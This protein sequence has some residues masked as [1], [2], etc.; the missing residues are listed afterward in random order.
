VRG[1]A[2]RA[3]TGR[4]GQQTA[5]RGLGDDTATRGLGDDTATRGE[6]GRDENTATHSPGRASLA[7]IAVILAAGGAITAA[8]AQPSPTPLSPAP[9]PSSPAAPSPGS[10]TRPAPDAS[11]PTPKFDH[12]AHRARKVAIDAC[13]SCHGADP[14]GALLAPGRSGH[15]PCLAAGCHVDQFLASGE[16][17]RKA[18]PARHAAAAAFCRG[19]HAT[20]AGEAPR[21]FEKARAD[22]VYRGET[23]PEHHIEMDHLAHVRLSAC[24]DC[25]AVDPTS[26]QLVADRPAHAECAACH[27]Q[28][29]PPMSQCGSCHRSPGPAAYFG[30]ARR[31]S[32]V[33]SCAPGTRPEPGTNPCFLHERREHR[34]AGGA[35]LQCSTCH[36][37]IAD[38]GRW[39]R[40]K[41]RTLRDLAAAPVIHNQR[42]QAHKSC[43][44]SGCHRRDVDD[45]RGTARC[46][47]CHSKRVTESIFD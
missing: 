20:A 18:D 47:L 28:S 46:S 9:A 13:A 32:D 16:A 41:Y 39:G 4:P 15:Q 25:H 6:R 34:F 42:D 1:A 38:P 33:R 23:A 43:G 12:A 19:C 21:R 7:M 3:A 27:G 36:F 5:T 29:A 35:E 44:A 30:P 11:A 8:A 45:S 40:Q 31:A 14:Q 17:T 26:F 10:P 2:G 24:R 22:N 37:M